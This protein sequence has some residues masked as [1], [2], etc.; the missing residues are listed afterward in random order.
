MADSSSK[1]LSPGRAPSSY[2]RSGRARQMPTGIWAR[3]RIAAAPRRWASSRFSVADRAPSTALATRWVHAEHIAA[4]TEA[5]RLIDGAG[6]T[7]QVAKRRRYAVAVPLEQLRKSRRREAALVV[8]PHRQREVVKREDGR[9]PLLAAGGEH[10]PVVVER[11]ARELALGRLDARPLDPEAECVVAQ[12]SLQRDVFAVAVVEVAGVARRLDARR[13][14][15]VLPPPPVAVGV[16]ALDL[17]GGH[18]GAEQEAGG[19]SGDGGQGT[20]RVAAQLPT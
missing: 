4:E 12:V 1:P 20:R 15:F 5:L 6:V 7:D 18:G 10:A 11:R 19:K 13:H 9:D 2:C 3:C 16:A 8:E 14:L 17:V